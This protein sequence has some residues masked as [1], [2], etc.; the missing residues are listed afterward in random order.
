MI[1]CYSRHP[2]ALH[3]ASRYWACEAT[4]ALQKASREAARV[5]GPLTRPVFLV[6]DNGP[7]F[8]ARSSQATL[9][10]I[11]LAGRAFSQVW[12][13]Y[14]TPTQLGL[15]ERFHGTLKCKRATGTC[16]PIRPMRE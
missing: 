2:L 14:R 8:I 10:G 11:E 7:S 6:T 13:A 1:D 16:T 3:L 9:A 4:H 12:I 5:H 15:L